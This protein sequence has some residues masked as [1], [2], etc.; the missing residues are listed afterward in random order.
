[1]SLRKTPALPGDSQSLTFPGIDKPGKIRKP[2][3]CEP[4]K[5]PEPGGFQWTTGSV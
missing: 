4:L 5:V 2:P 3:I 1:M